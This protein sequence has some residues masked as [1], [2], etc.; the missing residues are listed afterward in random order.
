MK[1]QK[2]S[3]VANILATYFSVVI[4]FVLVGC[5]NWMEVDYITMKHVRPFK[6][7]DLHLKYFSGRNKEDLID[8]LSKSSEW[9]V[10]PLHGTIFAIR[11]N[12]A[13]TCE[14][15]MEALPSWYR[16]RSIPGLKNNYLNFFPHVYQ[17][18]I[19]G[20]RLSNYAFENSEISLTMK[21]SYRREEKPPLV[22]PWSSNLV[23]RSEDKGIELSVFEKSD[24]TMLNMTKRYL[25]LFKSDVSKMLQSNS[26][27]RKDDLISVLPKSSFIMSAKE[28]FSVKG[29]GKT[30]LL[31]STDVYIV[32]GFVNRGKKGFVYLKL[33]TK[34]QN[35]FDLGNKE[36]TSAEYVGWSEDPNQKFNFCLGFRNI[37]NTLKPSE[38]LLLEFQVWF[39]PSDN[40]P[41]E[42]LHTQTALE[43]GF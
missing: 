1:Y 34:D 21:H 27:R 19:L 31:G 5:Y 30:G 11:R 7:P 10:F 43:K 40:S 22:I 29:V 39:K 36:G 24:D 18:P 33:L 20:S 9:H 28:S 8:F 13:K 32:S 14:P 41:E 35:A 26:L 37:R 15:I 2:R 25:N 16:D 38:T 12:D 42:L 4:G 17:P 3:S 6:V 23:I